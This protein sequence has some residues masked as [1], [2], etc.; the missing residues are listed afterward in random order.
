MIARAGWVPLM[1]GKGSS[2]SM[3]VKK[4]A[5][6]CTMEK[7]EQALENSPATK[8]AKYLMGFN[9][10][11]LHDDEIFWVDPTEM[12]HYWAKFYMP[13]AEKFDLKLVS[14]TASPSTVW[15]ISEFILACYGMKDDPDYPC[16]VNSISAFSIHAYNC[17]EKW[18]RRNF[19]GTKPTS[20]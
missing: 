6:A 14:P 10:P 18:W 12:A 8:S 20:F 1:D 5:Y 4:G 13:L 7:L 11:Y 17:K 3:K 16:D 2:C 19:D 15:H 9:E